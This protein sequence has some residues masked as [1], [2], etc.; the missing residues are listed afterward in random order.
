VARATFASV[1][2]GVVAVLVLL[3]VAS[4]AWSLAGVIV[5]EF[6]TLASFAREAAR[7][8]SPTGPVPAALRPSR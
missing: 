6:V 3:V 7:I 2:V 8:V 1:V 5:A 4:P